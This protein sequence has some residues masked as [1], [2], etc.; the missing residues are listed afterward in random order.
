MNIWSENEPTW[1]LEG[2]GKRS[3]RNLIFR[4]KNCCSFLILKFQQAKFRALDISS[5]VAKN[6]GPDSFIGTN[7]AKGLPI[8]VL[9][10]R[11]EPSSIRFLVHFARNLSFQQLI[12]KAGIIIMSQSENRFYK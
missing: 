10:R 5:L 2:E 12:N 3:L 9:R 11:K 8:K 6:P 4:Y 7:M 1:P